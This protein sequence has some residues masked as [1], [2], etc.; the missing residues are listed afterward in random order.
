MLKCVSPA[1][2]RSRTAHHSSSVVQH[3]ANAISEAWGDGAGK[4]KRK[5]LIVSDDADFKAQALSRKLKRNSKGKFQLESKEDM[6]SPDEADAL[7]AA[8]MPARVLV[9]RQVMGGPGLV[10]HIWAE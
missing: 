6:E 4:M 7:F 1:S 10:P 9:A 2:A 8:M 3:Y 5:E